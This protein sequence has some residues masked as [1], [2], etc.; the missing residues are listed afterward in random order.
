MGTARVKVFPNGEVKIEKI[1]RDIATYEI[2]VFTDL[3]NAS[4]G[5]GKFKF[6]IPEDLNG[7]L[8][9]DAQAFVTT[10]SSSGTPTIQIRNT[11]TGNDMLS[12][13]ITIDVGEKTS[14][15]AVSQRVINTSF[16][17]VSTGDE[18]SIDIDVAGTNAKGLGVI[19]VFGV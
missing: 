13:R 19:L 3:Q 8:L 11:T 16:D 15:T 5:D 1:I 10:T 9:T 4:T 12:T 18:I 6:A 14:Y 17:Q 7:A 2:K